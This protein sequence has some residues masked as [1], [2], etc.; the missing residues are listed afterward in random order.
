MK[1]LSDTDPKVARLQLELLRQAGP[2]KRLQIMASLS[3]M[4]AQLSRSH[5]EQKLGDAQAAKVEYIRIN[6][7]AEL[8]EKARAAQNNP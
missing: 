2:L 3:A 5:L 7:G 4:V 1:G 6:Y 8:A